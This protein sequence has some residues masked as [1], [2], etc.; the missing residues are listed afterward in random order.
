PS[1]LLHYSPPTSTEDCIRL[2]GSLK[3]VSVVSCI[4]EYHLTDLVSDK[5]IE[6]KVKFTNSALTPTVEILLYRVQSKNDMCID[7]VMVM[8]SAGDDTGSTSGSGSGERGTTGSETVLMPVVRETEISVV[9]EPHLLDPHT[10][11]TA[12]LSLQQQ[13]FSTVHFSTHRVQNVSVKEEGNGLVVECVFAE[14]SPQNITCTVVVEGEGGQWV[15]TFRGPLA[16]PHLPTGTY[17]VSVYDGEMRDLEPAV[18]TVAEVSGVSPSTSSTPS[19]GAATT[20]PTVHG[21]Q[22]MKG[23]IQRNTL[24]VVIGASGGLVVLLLAAVVII[25]LVVLVLRLR[26]RGRSASYHVKKFEDELTK[27]PPNATNPIIIAGD[28]QD[29]ESSYDKPPLEEGI[30]ESQ[31]PRQRSIIESPYEVV[32]QEEAKALREKKER[33]KRAR[34]EKTRS[35]AVKQPVFTEE[36]LLE[37]RRHTYSTVDLNKKK[38]KKRDKKKR[39]SSPPPVPPQAFNYHED[40]PEEGEPAAT[41]EHYSIQANG[42]SSHVYDSLQ[43]ATS[44]AISPLHTE[45]AV[46]SGKDQQ[47]TSPGPLTSGNGGGGDDVKKSGDP[48]YETITGLTLPPCSHQ[49]SSSSSSSPSSSPSSPLEEKET[50]RLIPQPVRSLS[51]LT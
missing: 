32:D 20:D 25:C 46:H 18:V 45:P 16:F 19:G 49:S 40:F 6:S 36:E 34:E 39:D 38:Q 21:G 48:V 11:Y 23:G 41:A 14:G 37:I 51:F 50:T 13:H 7:S 3:S 26:R 8:L 9:L 29:I 12:I 28:S 42:G 27:G 30:L 33:E 31:P 43:T 2:K 22:S 44:P 10:H 1:P 5:S 4:K 35:A 17:T 47:G 24:I 15:E